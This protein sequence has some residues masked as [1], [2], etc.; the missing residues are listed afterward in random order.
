MFRRLS[1][2]IAFLAGC[3]S[4][5]DPNPDR[6]RVIGIIGIYQGKTTPGVLLV[7]DTVALGSTF[8]VTITTYGSS[9]CTRPNGAEVIIKDGVAEII[10]YDYKI[11]SGFC[12]ADLRAFPRDV[13][14]RFGARGEALVRVQGRSVYGGIETVERRIVVH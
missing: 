1:F 2:L 4:T 8:K 13:Q 11:T 9:S 3:S 10:P 12:T 5:T 14:L 6:E 7:P